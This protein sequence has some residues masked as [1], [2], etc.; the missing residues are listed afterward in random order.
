MN[1]TEEKELRNTIKH[2]IRHVKQ[3]RLNEEQELRGIIRSM[4]DYEIQ[5]IL[6]EGLQKLSSILSLKI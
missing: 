6:M 5:A 3:K 1:L 4:I 2:L